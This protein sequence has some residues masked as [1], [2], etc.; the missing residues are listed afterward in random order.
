[1]KINVGSSKK[2]EF[3][4]YKVAGI[5]YDPVLYEKERNIKELYALMEEA[6]QNGAKLITMPEMATT[7]YCWYNREE[8]KPFIEPVPGPTDRKSVV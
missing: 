4:K 7:G 8:V 3:M 5:N 2:P 6:A 1:M